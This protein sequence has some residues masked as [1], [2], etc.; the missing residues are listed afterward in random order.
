MSFQLSNL[1]SSSRGNAS[2]LVVGDGDARRLFLI[3]A[4]L[5]PRRTHAL[6]AEVGLARVP[7]EGVLLT[8][9][10]NDHWHNGWLAAM[11][12]STTVHV[13]RSHRG[14]A[15]R[16][17]LTYLRTN[18]FDDDFEIAPGVVVKPVLNAHDDLG[19]AA[20]RIEYRPS[21]TTQ[22]HSSLGFAT[23]IGSPTRDLIQ[24]LQGVDVLAV[25]SNYCPRMQLA[26]NRPQFLKDRIMGGAG[27]LSNQ[28]SAKLVRDIAPQ[29][30]VLLLHLSLECNTP[31]VAL[32]AHDWT[33]DA[34][35]PACTIANWDGPTPW[36]EIKPTSNPRPARQVPLPMPRSLWDLTNSLPNA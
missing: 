21:D 25:E 11:P 22:P 6:L 9:L 7:I 26:S 13:H 35:A 32:R 12:Q 14:R 1:S 20:F 36:I 19:T 29:S 5:S 28:Q 16:A 23:D 30:H 15:D 33:R 34:D 2:A 8:H 3:D 10:D 18:L 17:G 24:H 27:H 31:D 4:G